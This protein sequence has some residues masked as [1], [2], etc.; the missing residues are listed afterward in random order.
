MTAVTPP[1]LRLVHGP[2]ECLVT[3]G[4]GGSVLALRHA[5]VDVLR[6][7]PD[8]I[9]TAR[10]AA[11]YPLVPFSNRIGQGRLQWGGRTWSLEGRNGAEPHPIHGVGWQD[12]WQV[13]AV[14]QDASEAQLRLH[15][16][17]DARWPFAFDATQRFVLDGTGLTLELSLTNRADEPAPAGLGWHPFFTKR[18]G[19]RI[20][21]RTAT[22]W[23]MGDDALPTRRVPHEGLATACDTLEVDHCF[24]G[25]DRV[26]SLRD[27]VFAITVTSTLD[28]VVVFTR[29]GR[30]DLAIEPVSHANNA[31]GDPAIAALGHEAGMRELAP[32]DTFAARMRIEVTRVA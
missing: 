27:D 7:V 3:P 17:G 18:P 19:A 32:G 2:F 1:T 16:P 6:R 31:F 29:P 12:P 22:R 23:E 5:G 9:A 10:Q 20:D 30:G 11:S 8:D 25:W 28:Q 14:A 26:A 13:V 4:L 24:G 21:V 15:H